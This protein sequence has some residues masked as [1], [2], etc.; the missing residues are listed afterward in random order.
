MAKFR[1]RLDTLRRLREAARDG[2]RAALAEA[3]RAEELL[4]EQQE[5]LGRELERL[6]AESRAAASPGRIDVDRLLDA[7]R[8]ELVLRA[9]QKQLAAQ[10]E[11]VA[12]EVERRRQAL[13]EA[14]REVRVLESLRE[15]HLRRHREEEAR[16]ETK[17]LDEAAAVRAARE[18][19]A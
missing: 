4:R 8:Y 5:H 2:R 6:A 17:E 7:R 16:R 13:V 9:H 15:K 14:D 1:F 18:V 12:E 3:Y 10:Q 11:N 19:P